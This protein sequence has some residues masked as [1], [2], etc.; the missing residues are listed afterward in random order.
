[1]F[2][3]QKF[4]WL[5]LKILFELYKDEV[6]NLNMIRSLKKNIESLTEVE[7]NK[8]KKKQMIEYLKKEEEKLM[9]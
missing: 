4:I 1:M 2:E 7:N 9:K 3:D 8:Q 5:K 6:M